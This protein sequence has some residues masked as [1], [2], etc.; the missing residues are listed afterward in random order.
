VCRQSSA[1][2]AIPAEAVAPASP[3]S[4]SDALDTLAALTPLQYGDVAVLGL[5]SS[6]P[7]SLSSRLV[8]ARAHPCLTG[9]LSFHTITVGTLFSHLILLLFSIKELCN[10][11]APHQLRLIELMEELN[12]VYKA[13]GRSPSSIHISG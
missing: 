4:K 12:Q 8:G 3:L 13:G 2:E 11:L 10:S 6:S 9:F 1:A 5:A 7:T